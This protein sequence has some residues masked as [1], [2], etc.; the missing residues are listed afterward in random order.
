MKSIDFNK[1]KIIIYGYGQGLANL[2][3][4]NLLQLE[5]ENIIAIVDKNIYGGGID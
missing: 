5:V 3:K 4:S 2:F 1:S